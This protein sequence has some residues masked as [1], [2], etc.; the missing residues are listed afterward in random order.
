MLNQ[1]FRTARAG[2]DWQIIPTLATVAR[3]VPDAEHW[4]SA[5]LDSDTDT[6]L[7]G[8]ATRPPS[9]GD[10]E[11]CRIPLLRLKEKFQVWATLF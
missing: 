11:A 7:A 3:L 2:M 10:P 1:S 8:V 6:D 9:L 4:Y 5:G